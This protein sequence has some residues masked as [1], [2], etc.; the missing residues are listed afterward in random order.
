[1]SDT[2]YAKPKPVENSAETPAENHSLTAIS[3]EQREK[4][5]K[6]SKFSTAQ[7]ISGEWL[8]RQELG[9]E[10]FSEEEVHWVSEMFGR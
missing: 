6:W 2:Q 9:E 5:A 7:G 3:A 10:S 4:L 8:L 1:M